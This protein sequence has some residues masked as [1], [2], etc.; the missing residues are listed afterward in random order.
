MKL[1]QSVDLFIRSIQDIHMKDFRILC[2]I[3]RLDHL[4]I[5]FI[6]K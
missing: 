3:Q 5:T 2:I 4:P 6:Q 1:V